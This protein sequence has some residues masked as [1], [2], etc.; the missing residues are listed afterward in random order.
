MRASLA[1]SG[2][3]SVT[4]VQRNQMPGW[5]KLRR[6]GGATAR[7]KSERL[8]RLAVAF[9]RPQTGLRVTLQRDRATGTDRLLGG[10]Q[11]LDHSNVHVQ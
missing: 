10:V 1:H 7:E 6:N 9:N 3:L 5:T 11:N 4:S 2:R 8:E